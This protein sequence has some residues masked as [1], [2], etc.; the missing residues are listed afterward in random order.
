MAV[1]FKI[2]ADF[3]CNVKRGTSSDRGDNNSYTETD[4]DHIPCSFVCKII[5]VDDKFSKPVVLY[6]GK[7]AI[8]RFVE[9]VLKEYDYCKKVMNK[10]FNKNLVM[11]AEDKKKIS[12]K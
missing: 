9:V 3:E 5:C 7:N 11:S 12:V 4:Q 8:Y 10:H 1:L 2:Y 6:K